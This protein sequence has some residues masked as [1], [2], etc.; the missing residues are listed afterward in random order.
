LTKAQQA[1]KDGDN[2]TAL[3]SYNKVLELDAENKV[4]HEAL[5][6]IAANMNIA[7]QLNTGIQLY[8]SGKEKRAKQTFEAVLTIDRNNPIAVE[9]LKKLDLTT[10]KQTT[11]EDLQQN[12]DIWKLYL[13]GLRYM[14]NKEYQKA[15][16]AWNKVLKVYPNN[17]NTLNNL[18]QAMLRLESEKSE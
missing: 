12:K 7:Q 11:L 18:E 13:D 14:R 1:E 4:A 5:A 17:I 10:A 16:D 6:R 3:T 8:N 15:V 9:Y 2:L